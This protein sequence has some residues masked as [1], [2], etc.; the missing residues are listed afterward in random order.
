MTTPFTPAASW[1]ERMA[2][3]QETARRQ[4]FFI[5]GAPRSGTT[6][7][8]G[9][10]DSHPEISCEGEGLFWQNLATPLDALVTERGRAIAEKNQTLF[11]HTGGYRLPGGGDADTL[12]GTG[13]L[14]ALSQQAAAKPGA[15]ALGE[16]TPE[17]VFLFPRLKR[18]F[19]AAKLFCIAR[20]PRDTVA[21]AWHIFQAQ[22]EAADGESAKRDFINSILPAL[23][24]GLR[25]TLILAERYPQDVAITT[26]EALQ[27][28]AAPV[29]ENFCRM[30][31][32]SDAPPLIAASIAQ[33]RFA[34]RKASAPG[35]V[36]LRNGRSGTWAETLTPGMAAT[37]LS[38]VGWSYSRFGWQA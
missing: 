26:Y 23:D 32:V 11:R 16:K 25:A 6:W 13:V 36:F 19:P 12:L 1:Q 31:G 21:S 30:L 14:M 4:I 35:S 9:L 3:L 38:H 28:D 37:I 34:T 8:G 24:R 29:L 2:A 15:R 33:N 17:N 7:L 18:L 20:D 27:A 5:G 10:L 22:H